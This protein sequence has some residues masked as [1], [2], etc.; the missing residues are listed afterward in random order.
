MALL[1]RQPC[2]GL[3]CGRPPLLLPQTGGL[4]GAGLGLPTLGPSVLPTPTVPTLEAAD[5]S[6]GCCWARPGVH[7]LSARSPEGWARWPCQVR[8]RKPTCHVQGPRV[9]E[10]GGHDPR[11]CSVPK[12]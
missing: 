12:G 2:R 1:P 4:L 9:S 10:G 8:L 5:P 6:R 3:I 7:S 11:I